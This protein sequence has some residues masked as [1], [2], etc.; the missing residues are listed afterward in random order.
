MTTMVATLTRSATARRRRTCSAV[1][2]GVERAG[3]GVTLMRAPVPAKARRPRYSAASP[4]P[5]SMRS[6]WLYFAVRSLRAGAPDLICPQ[7]VATARSA[8]VDVLGL[9]RAVRHHRGVGVAAGERHRVERL[10]QRADLVDLH[11]DRVG[12]A[13]VDPPL[14]AGGIGDEEVV[15]DELHPVADGRR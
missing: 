1:N 6:N 11:E 13:E 7:F 9:A 15:T 3:G 5:S 14:Q 4:R 2:R 8:I 10:R 12:D